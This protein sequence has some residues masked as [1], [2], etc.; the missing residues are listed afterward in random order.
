[1]FPIRI[2]KF[3]SEANYCSRREADRLIS[4]K[5]V[6]I[7]DQIASLGDKVEK[8]DQ[9][10]VEGLEIRLTTAEKIYLVFHKPVGIICTSAKVKDNIID[11]INYPERIYAV[12]RLDVASS[13]LILLTNDGELAN[14]ILKAQSKIEKEYLVTVSRK[15]TRQFL[16][17]LR[18]GVVIDHYKTLPAKVSRI[19]DKIFSIAI[20]EGK[21]RQIR[22]MCQRFGYDVLK[23]KRIRIGSLNLN[24]LK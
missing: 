7:N 21:N 14:K 11:Y 17:N 16:E 6:K 2:N 24:K 8:N 4:A 20:V 13:G 19:S 3:L 15:L 10:F 1:M 18:R 22:K 5:K 12:G 9:V 23:L